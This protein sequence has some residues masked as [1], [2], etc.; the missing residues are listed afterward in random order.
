VSS[1]WEVGDTAAAEFMGP[2]YD[3]LFRGESKTQALRSAKLR[4]LESGYRH[5][6]FWAAFILHGDALTGI[7]PDGL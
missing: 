4:M 5:P 3:H 1:L 6:F 7:G 2:F